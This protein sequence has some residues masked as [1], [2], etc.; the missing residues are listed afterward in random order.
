MTDALTKL[1]AP[2]GASVT[3]DFIRA[4]AIW[5]VDGTLV[6]TAELHYRAWAEICRR[7]DFEMTPEIFAQT[8][9]LQNVAILRMLFGER[10]AGPEFAAVGD[11][12]EAAYRRLVEFH[13]V[14]LL[15]G[16]EQLLNELPRLGFVQGIGSS[17][18]KI[19]VDL[20]LRVTGAES[21]FA[22]MSTADDTNRGKPEPDVFL[23]AARKLGVPPERCVVFEDAPAG[24]RAAKSAGMAAVG[25]AFATHHS[26]ESLHEAGADRVVASLETFSAAEALDLSARNANRAKTNDNSLAKS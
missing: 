26:P 1:P 9:G 14:R 19:N 11:E 8:F 15:P 7:R 20:I 25:V 21:A 24:I 6:D 3:T 22:A 4:G 17:A 13:G 10:G 5:D 23:I 2:H 18:P 12:K 16:V